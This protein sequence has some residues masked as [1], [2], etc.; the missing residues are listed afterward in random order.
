VVY[1]ARFGDSEAIAE[2]QGIDA[3]SLLRHGGRWRIVSL[4]FGRTGEAP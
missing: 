2:W 1:R 4:A 3:I